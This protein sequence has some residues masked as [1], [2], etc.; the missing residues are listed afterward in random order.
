MRSGKLLASASSNSTKC[1]ELYM[2]F[3]LPGTIGRSRNIRRHPAFLPQSSPNLPP[4]FP[5]M[6]MRMRMRM[7]GGVWGGGNSGICL[8][9]WKSDE[10][11]SGT[12]GDCS[13]RATAM[14]PFRNP[15]HGAHFRRPEAPRPSPSRRG[16]GR[17]H[18]AW[19][20]LVLH[21]TP[22]CVGWPYN[23]HRGLPVEAVVADHLVPLQLWQSNPAKAEAQLRDRLMTRSTKPPEQWVLDAWSLDNGQ[24]LCLA[25]H[26]RK[27]RLER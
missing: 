27:S 16:Y 3:S 8:L 12:N 2:V 7:R 18:Q 24:P 1:A 14:S 17:R 23:W 9:T 22:Y 21:E 26:G 25:C 10:Q 13:K 20:L 15:R 6:R 11:N 19:R 5:R 4:G